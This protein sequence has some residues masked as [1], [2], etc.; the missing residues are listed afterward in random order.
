MENSGDAISYRMSGNVL[1]MVTA[2]ESEIAPERYEVF[3]SKV[4]S[5][6]YAILQTEDCTS[7]VVESV[8]VVEVPLCKNGREKFNVFAAECQQCSS[9]FNCRF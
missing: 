5:H 9:F 8:P 3:V 7:E 1:I 6:G 2:I 4:K